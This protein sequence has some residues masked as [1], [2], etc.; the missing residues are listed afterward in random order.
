MIVLGN[1]HSLVTML[2]QVCEA[3]NVPTLAEALT[4]GKP[5]HLFRSTEHL[6][7]CPAI[8]DRTRVDHLV[9]LNFD[10]GKPVHITYHTEHLVSSTGKMTLVFRNPA[11]RKNGGLERARTD[12]PAAAV[13]R[14]PGEG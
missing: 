9:R 4:L 12:P 2:L 1:D 5:T 14:P 6:A 8:Y 3:L 13:K 10:P 7:P 11:S